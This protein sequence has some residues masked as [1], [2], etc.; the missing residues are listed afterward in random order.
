[1]TAKEHLTIIVCV[2]AT[3]SCKVTPVV[4]GYPKKPRCFNRMASPCLPYY[5]QKNAWND[6]AIY[7]KWW[8]EVFIP[9]I[10]KHTQDP[11]LLGLD[12]FSDHDDHC[13]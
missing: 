12:N 8:N 6:T 9:T 3:G 2:N 7:N 10:R 1:M 4:I 5:S 13:N 11:V